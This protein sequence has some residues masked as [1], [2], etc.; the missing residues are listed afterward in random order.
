MTR[1]DAVVVAVPARDEEAR[2]PA[3]L[4]AIAAAAAASRVPVVVAVAAD[5]CTDRT[6]EIAA[7]RGVLVVPSGTGRVG[8]ARSAAVR[9][10]LAAVDAAPGAVWVASTDADSVVPAD[11]LTVHL[12]FAADGV[13][14]LRGSVRPDSD[15]PTALARTWARRNPRQERHDH[16]HGANLGVRADVL[17]AAGGFPDLARDEDVALVRAVES[18]GERV[19][20]TDA[21]PVLTS[22]RMTGRTGGGFAGYLRE[23]AAEER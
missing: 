14:L 8:G 19:V 12:R 2:L 20:S 21:A 5:S 22:G 9:A 18:L 1:I 17:L 23:L 3:A 7:E 13:G 15:L 6:A 16:V 10:G 4:D 11:W